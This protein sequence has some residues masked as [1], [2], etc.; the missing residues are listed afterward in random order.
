VATADWWQL[1]KDRTKTE[2]KRLVVLV[3]VGWKTWMG[4]TPPKQTTFFLE[5]KEFLHGPN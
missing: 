2:S 4:R 1:A 3:F 5:G